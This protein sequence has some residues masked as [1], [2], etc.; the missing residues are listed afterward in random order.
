MADDTRIRNLETQMHGQHLVNL[1]LITA[2][3]LLSAGLLIAG[4]SMRGGL[5]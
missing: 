3:F 1:G 5:T 2:V 4:F